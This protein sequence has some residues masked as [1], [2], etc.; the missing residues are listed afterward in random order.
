VLYVHVSM[1]TRMHKEY[2]QILIQIIK[3]L[4]IEKQRRIF[5]SI[6]SYLL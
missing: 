5:L 2:F 3:L 1:L 4:K 6:C